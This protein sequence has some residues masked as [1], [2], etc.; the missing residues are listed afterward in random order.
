MYRLSFI[1]FILLLNLTVLAQSPHGKNFSRDCADC[2]DAVSW[3]LLK[4][5][6]A[7]N[8]DNTNFPLIGQHKNQECRQCHTTLVFEKAR[9]ECFTCHKDIHKNTVSLDC[10][11]CHTPENWL[12]KDITSLHQV[13][14][15]PLIGVHQT[16]DC[17]QCHNRF[18]DLSFEVPGIS[19]YDCHVKEFLLTQNP[20]H[21]QSGF[22]K[23][24]QECHSINSNE[25]SS[26]EFS[27]DFFPLIGGH[28]IANCFTCHKQESFTGLSKDCYTC[29]KT[30][31]ESSTNPNH[32]QAKFSTNCIECHN[33]N[34]W[35]PAAFNHATTGFE[36]TGGHS[37]VQC[38][39]CHASGYENTSNECNACHN[40]DYV[41]TTNPN[42]IAAN[43]PVTCK[44]CHNTNSWKPATFNHD[45]QFFPIY[46]GKHKEKWNN[47][48]DC[49]TNQNNYTVFSCI[50][51]HEHNQTEMNDKHSGISGYLYNSTACFECHPN[52]SS[53]GA[54]NHSTSRFP[55]V[56]KHTTTQCQDCHSSG[57]ANTPMECASCHQM[58]FNNSLNPNHS[59][60]GLSTNCSSCHN[61]N[62]WIPSLFNHSATN[63]PLAGQHITAKCEDC[64]KGQTTGTSQVCYSC[65]KS[66]FDNSINPNHNLIGLATTCETCHNSNAWIPSSFSH[67]AT[68]FPL[69][70]QHTA[71][72]CEDCHK[73]QTT[74]TTQL[75]SGCHQN[76]FNNSTNPNHIQ[77]KFS[78]NCIECHTVNGWRPSTFN[79]S[80]TG[81]V[82]TGSH[83]TVQC[84]GC[85]SAG[86]SN[87][88]SDCNSCHNQDYVATTNPNHTAAQF[89]VTCQDCHNTNN[90]IP[91]SF[92]HDGNYFPIYSGTHR[93]KWNTCSDC[94]TNQSNY[95]VFSCIDCHE[96]SNQAEVNKDH[97][98][99][100]NYVYNSNACY[101]C[102]PG[103]NNRLR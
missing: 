39:S 45:G 72:K 88:K 21:S 41:A 26:T 32:T 62:G 94:H 85:H 37:S 7:F 59:V 44:D 8:H 90:W 95:T 20:N 83:T 11:K 16:K 28:K 100:A 80:T 17:Q 101:Q 81:F 6:M 68:A 19:C 18:S 48:N 75:C 22:S 46:S 71:A 23:D 86:Y 29:H 76:D 12:V 103:G 55:L 1:I 36:L 69:V 34:G 40:K 66:G 77:A 84:S 42:H 25:W 5:Q 61:P 87:T 10:G 74:G 49:H 58:D 24:C 38:S 70:G 52:G 33:V 65:H 50:N 31:F 51:C 3:K 43:F 14:R 78:S 97:N 96:H 99:V 64:H 82:L 92:N 73:G 98:E 30:N 27:H 2:H 91:A 47:C 53:E 102:H 63:F 35:K 54:F 9:Q 79:H 4:E 89:P 60:I 15:F 67:S 56:G 93:E 57:Y 13:N